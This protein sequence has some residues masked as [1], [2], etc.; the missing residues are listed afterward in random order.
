M[1]GEEFRGLICRETR[2]ISGTLVD[3]SSVAKRF[4]YL[5]HIDWQQHT[6]VFIDVPEKVYSYD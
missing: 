4:A 5:P 3:S 6:Y 2:V 1:K